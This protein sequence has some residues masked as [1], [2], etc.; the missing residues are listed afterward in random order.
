[1]KECV[2]SYPESVTG[3]LLELWTPGPLELQS[4]DLS[5]FMD[6]ILARLLGSPVLRSPPLKHS[7]LLGT[8]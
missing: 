6:L 1:M 7:T 3:V 2:P 4:I 8:E 5:S